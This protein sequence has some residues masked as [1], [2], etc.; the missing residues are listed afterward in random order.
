MIAPFLIKFG[1]NSSV[2]A[3]END[4]IA[5]KSKTISSRAR[6]RESIDEPDFPLRN[7]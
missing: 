4:S 7:Y 1:M 6:M 5:T 2:P 3:G